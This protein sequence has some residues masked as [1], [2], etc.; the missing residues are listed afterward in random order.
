MQML[1]PQW[2]VFV[3]VR[4]TPEDA[5]NHHCAGLK[6][7]SWWQRDF[8]AQ[9]PTRAHSVEGLVG[10]HRQSERCSGQIASPAITQPLLKFMSFSP[11]TL[12]RQKNLSRMEKWMTWLVTRYQ[13]SHRRLWKSVLRLQEGHLWLQ[14]TS[15]KQEPHLKSHLRKVMMKEPKPQRG[16]MSC[17][18]KRRR[19]SSSTYQSRHWHPVALEMLWTQPA[20]H[21]LCYRQLINNVIRVD[22]LL[23]HMNAS[24]PVEVEPHQ[25]CAFSLG[26]YILS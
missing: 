6:P 20:E 9:W 3:V 14:E 12:T 21:V 11:Q 8:W 2:Q 13:Q 7:W 1:P 23:I 19:K 17:L 10:R 18:Q 24:N 16:H 22:L 4:G 15:P 26:W 5:K 25:C